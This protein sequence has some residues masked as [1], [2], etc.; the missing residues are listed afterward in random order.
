MSALLDPDSLF[1][2][3][4]IPNS[5]TMHTLIDSGSSHCFMDLSFVSNHKITTMIP[6]VRLHL[7]DGTC[8]SVITQ[9]AELPISFPNGTEFNLTFYV[10]PLD[11]SCSAVLEFNW[12]YKYN[13]LIDLF[14]G[15]ITF[16]TTEKRGQAPSTSSSEAATPK[17]PPPALNSSTKHPNPEP[18]PPSTPPTSPCTSNT[19]PHISMINATAYLWAC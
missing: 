2:P 19:P 3:L 16:H 9:T 7:F 5:E 18:I 4:T 15:T 10:T 6:S 17:E 12:L 14:T 8:N 11:S 1:I 13:P